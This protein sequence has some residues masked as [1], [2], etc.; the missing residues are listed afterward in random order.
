MA[1][2]MWKDFERSLRDY[3]RGVRIPVSGQEKDGR[4]VESLCGRFDYQAKRVQS[5]PKKVRY[6]L[7]GI[8]RTAEP[9]NRIGLVVIK[10]PGED[11][12]ESMVI[13]QACDWLAVLDLLELGD[14]LAELY[15]KLVALNIIQPGDRVDRALVERLTITLQSEAPKHG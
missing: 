8:R 7:D 12:A 15:A 5:A 13:L 11:R 3:F 10:A 1:R 14:D 6:W 9:R 4:D 2:K